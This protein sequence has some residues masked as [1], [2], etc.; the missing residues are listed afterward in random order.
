ILRQARA[1]GL[2]L[3]CM[4]PEGAGNT[5]RSASAGAA[6]AG[7]PVTLPKRVNAGPTRARVVAA[8]KARQQGPSGPCG[9]RPHAAV[10]G[11]ADGIRLAGS[12]DPAK[13]AAA[14]RSNTLDTPTGQLAF[15][16]KGDLKDLNFV[17]YEWHADGSKPA[18]T[19]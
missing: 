12:A 2:N 6:A 13:V 8:F 7:T 18:L 9:R 4:G 16:E 11:I 14:L 1:Q 19:Q 15:D 17:V 3:P 5:D 10:Q